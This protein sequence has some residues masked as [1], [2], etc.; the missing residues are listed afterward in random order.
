MTYKVLL[1][2]RGNPDY[3]QDPGRPLHG[4]PKDHWIDAPS[5]EVCIAACREYIREYD[6]GSGNWTGGVVVMR[7]RVD[8]LKEKLDTR[9]FAII[10]V[11]AYGG[12]FFPIDEPH[13][14]GQPWPVHRRAIAKLNKKN[15]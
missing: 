4:S 8:H 9:A 5:I 13:G 14:Y 3:Q 12:H 15:S 10:G 2:N 11:I 6:L 7:G 1:S